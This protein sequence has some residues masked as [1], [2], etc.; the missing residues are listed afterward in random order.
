MLTYYRHYHNPPICD[1]PL[2][3]I[4]SETV[5]NN[6]FSNQKDASCCRRTSFQLFHPKTRFPWIPVV[7]RLSWI[8]SPVTSYSNFCG[9]RRL[10]YSPYDTHISEYCQTFTIS[11]N[12][13]FS[14]FL[15]SVT[16]LK[17]TQTC[18]SAHK[19]FGRSLD[20]LIR[21]TILLPCRNL[22]QRRCIS[23]K[24]QLNW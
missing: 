20:R 2:P 6:C 4:L 3:S 24:C 14:R 21:N 8:N 9:L 17:I 18:P 10:T 16:V 15:I 13:S 12:M 11:T 5:T 22:F 19:R 23:R 7:G 1:S